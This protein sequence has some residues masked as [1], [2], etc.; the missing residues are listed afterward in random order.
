MTSRGAHNIQNSQDIQKV[1]HVSGAPVVLKQL[2]VF[3]NWNTLGALRM[4][5]IVL[6]TNTINTLQLFE[7]LNMLGAH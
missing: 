2:Y 3:R 4:I 7:L 1:L 5:R 6:V